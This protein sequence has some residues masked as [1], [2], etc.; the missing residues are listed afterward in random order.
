MN[1]Q[2]QS[3]A[4]SNRKIRTIGANKIA[5]IRLGFTLPTQNVFHSELAITILFVVEHDLI[6]EFYMK[7]R[8]DF[9]NIYTKYP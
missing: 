3:Y 7:N 5:K 1:K 6:Y 4:D 9:R 2:T 8:E